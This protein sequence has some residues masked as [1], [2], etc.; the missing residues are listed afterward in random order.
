MLR[1]KW[2]STCAGS[3]SRQLNTCRRSSAG[4]CAAGMGACMRIIFLG[5]LVAMCGQTQL[6][7]KKDPSYHPH[8]HQ[9]RH[10]PHQCKRC[11]DDDDYNYGCD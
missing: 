6:L 11:D 8:H 7:G 1:T 5:L 4:Q 2:H 9:H 10:Q 3:T